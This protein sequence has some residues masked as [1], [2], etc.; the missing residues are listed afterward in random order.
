MKIE[1]ATRPR[2]GMCKASENGKNCPEPGKWRNFCQHHYNYFYRHGL[3]DLTGEERAHKRFGDLVLET[4]G[5][6][7]PGICHLVVDDERC[8]E[9][10]HCRGLCKVHYD[11]VRHNGCIELY[12]LSSSNI[13]NY[14]LYEDAGPKE[15][16]IL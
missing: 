13:K 11:I 10:S 2:K 9:K 16:R 5:V 3:L 14:E 4:A 7:I 15:C 6:P 1:L 12:G 8:V